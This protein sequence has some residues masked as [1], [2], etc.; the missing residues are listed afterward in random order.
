MSMSISISM[1][2]LLTIDSIS[3]LNLAIL[4]NGDSDQLTSSDQFLDVFVIFNGTTWYLKLHFWSSSRR[5]RLEVDE[6]N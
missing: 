3:P 1:T 6:S 5:R 4:K 2:R